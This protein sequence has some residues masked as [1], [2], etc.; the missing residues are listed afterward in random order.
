MTT[1]SSGGEGRMGVRWRITPVAAKTE[2]GG[3][4]IKV[5]PVGSSAR[6]QQKVGPQGADLT[7]ISPHI[8]RTYPAIV[9]TWAKHD[10]PTPVIT[11]GNDGKHKTGSR[12]YSDEAID[13]RCNNLPDEVCQGISRDLARSLGPD[14]DVQFEKFKNPDWDHVHV[15]Y[16]PKPRPAASKPQAS[17][18]PGDELG[19]VDWMK[20]RN[21]QTGWG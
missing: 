10:G 4:D 2:A 21:G 6:L 16:D 20:W 7:A 9:E 19:I 11:S 12:H 8:V 5:G 1:D 14:Y 17:P 18:V 13:L 3:Q 15:E